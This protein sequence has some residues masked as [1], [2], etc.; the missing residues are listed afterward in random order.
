MRC[1]MYKTERIHWKKAEN[2]KPKAF[3]SVLGHIKSAEPFP[4]VRECYIIGNGKFFF[5]ALNTTEEVD[6][7][8]D[9]PE[10]TPA[11]MIP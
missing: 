1:A 2:E 11:K 5:P 10:C 8:A 9:M 6:W 4:E 7:W 3:V